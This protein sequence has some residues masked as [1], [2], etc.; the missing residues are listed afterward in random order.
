M[1]D[2]G[3]AAAAAAPIGD[4]VPLFT[5]WEETP[6]VGNLIPAASPTPQPNPTSSADAAPREGGDSAATGAHDGPGGS[7]RFQYSNWR[8]LCLLRVRLCL[9]RCCP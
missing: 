8:R 5:S 3:T 4:N 6:K 2:P 9:C 1:E 7:S